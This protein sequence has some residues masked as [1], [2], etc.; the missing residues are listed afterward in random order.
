MSDHT[1]YTKGLWTSF[2]KE[3]DGFFYFNLSNTSGIVS[4][5]TLRAIADKM[6]EL[7]KPWEEQ[8]KKDE[9]IIS[10]TTEEIDL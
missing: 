8:I 7:N 3:V 5:N 4:S 2:V 10:E 6:D 9:S 1:L